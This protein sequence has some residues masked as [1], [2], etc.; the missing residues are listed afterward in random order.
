M[1]LITRNT[2][3]N[4][5][6]E[7][8]TIKEMDDNLLYLEELAVG[9]LLS[10]R[11]V[12]VAA[13]GTPTENAQEFI[14]AYAKAV[15]AERDEDNRFTILLSQGRYQFQ[16]TFEHNE[17]Y[18]NIVSLSGEQ[19]VIFDLDLDGED[20][21][22]LD[23]P[24][25]S[26]PFKYI[27]DLTIDINDGDTV[28]SDS[29][30]SSGS[31]PSFLSVTGQEFPEIVFDANGLGFR[32]NP[33]NVPVPVYTDFVV[34]NNDIIKVSYHFIHDAYTGENYYENHIYV[35]DDSTSSA[36]GTINMYQM[37]GYINN[38]G[39]LTIWNP[40][41]G[42][43]TGFSLT[44]GTEYI[45]ELI[46]DP[47][48]LT[49]TVNVKTLSGDIVVTTSAPFVA[50]SGSSY[51][52]ALGMANQ[53][54]EYFPSIVKTSS[55]MDI[56][57]DYS[58]V[59]GIKTR[60]YESSNYVSWTSITEEITEDSYYPLPLNVIVNDYD[61]LEVKNCTAGPFSFGSDWGPDNFNEGRDLLA[62]FTDCTALAYSF[63]YG[64]DD[65]RE[66]SVFTNCKAGNYSF[67]IY[68]YLRGT[69]INCTAGHYSFYAE[70]EDVEGTFTNCTA[71]D[72]SFYSDD[73]DIT[74]VSKFT[75]CTAGERSFYAEDD[76][77]RGTYINCTA[78]ERSFYADGDNSGTYRNCIADVGSFDGDDMEGM[79]CYY[80]VL[81]GGT[82]DGG[83]Q[84]YCVDDNY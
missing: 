2:G 5:K 67:H 38:E 46:Q 33:Y 71:G 57:A 12:Y 26:V 36:F 34:N 66:D 7:K 51:R 21:F 29:L 37:Y 79:D 62:K 76:D 81:N 8:L 78:G 10:T 56:S 47:I 77:N 44:N 63:G 50:P 52:I 53:G 41:T 49:Q 23:S 4:S 30:K 28:Y 58:K 24:P 22:E 13:N 11:Y 61:D 6:G 84:Y 16:E 35:Y 60:E 39:Y 40:S 27:F 25:P 48:G 14:E 80:C 75:N 54:P 42:I 73:E 74:S 82:F 83:N 9:G 69:F 68:D 15:D 55:V 3:A 32:G 45:F 43:G 64:A 31:V 18:I 70:D 65:M 17:D 72:R 20:P 59:N 19:D 1:A